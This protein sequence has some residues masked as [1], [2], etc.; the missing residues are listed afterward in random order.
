LVKSYGNGIGVDVYNYFGN[1]DVVV[2]SSANMPFENESFDTIT[3]VAS[4]NHI[5]NYGETL[6]ESLRILKP[7]G[8][9]LIT[10][11]IVLPM[12]LWHKIAH[13]YDEDQIYR[14]I[15]EEEERYS[16]PIKE[17]IDSLVKNGFK[18][19]ERKKF[20]FGLNNLIIAKK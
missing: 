2:K 17:I 14:G 19:P 18:Q 3:I 11:P 5:K 8:K 9:I 16:M 7:N 6:K 10:M 20:L 4:L 1:V 13:D 15:N 12:K